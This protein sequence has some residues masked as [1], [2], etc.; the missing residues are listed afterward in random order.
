[1]EQKMSRGDKLSLAVLIVLVVFL[2][3]VMVFRCNGYAVVVSRQDADGSGTISFKE[4]QLHIGKA[5]ESIHDLKSGDTVVCKY[6][7]PE[8]GRLFNLNA[9]VVGVNEDEMVAVSFEGN[10]QER[11]VYLSE[12]MYRVL[13]A[14]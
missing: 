14:M 13:P 5:P 3:G 4:V 1:M 2:V 10:D 8:T 7:S 9:Q 11:E 12:I 6:Y